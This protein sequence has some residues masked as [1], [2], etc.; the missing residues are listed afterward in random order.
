MR[1]LSTVGM[2]KNR[3]RYFPKSVSVHKDTPCKDVVIILN[4]W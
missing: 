3:L 2:E 4:E 1:V